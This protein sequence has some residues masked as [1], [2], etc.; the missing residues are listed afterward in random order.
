MKYIKQLQV[1]ILILYM[2]LAFPMFY[3]AYKFGILLQGYKDAESYLKLYENL[4]SPEVESP[5]NMR[6]I[7]ASIIHFMGKFGWCY[8]TEC[9]IDAFPQFNKVYYFNNLFFNFFCISLTSY[10]ICISFIKLGISKWLSFMSGMLYLL[11]F[12]TLFY[13]M[14]PGPDA[15]SVLVF[16]WL[17]YFYLQ[18]HVAVVPFFLILIL[19]REYYFLVFMIVAIMD[20]IKS[21]DRY[22]LLVWLLSILCFLTYFI[23]RKTIFHT[24]HWA[25]QTSPEFLLHTLFNSDLQPIQLI[26]QTA[27]T[28]NIFFIY[29]GLI[30]YKWQKGLSINKHYLVILLYVIFEITILSYAAT[31]GTNNGRYFYLNI[32]F[33]LYLI[34][35][36]LKPLE[37]KLISSQS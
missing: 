24:H 5:F 21:K 31:F 1:P 3:F 37:S 12:G 4:S 10:S 27:M 15:F 2:L 30:V 6:L 35:L 18:K 14:M 7:S 9:A 11:G 29:L 33:I 8:S 26:K 20:F 34:C 32:P 17:L 22:Y 13:L 19:Q 23:L 36:E 16:T 28:M 25:H